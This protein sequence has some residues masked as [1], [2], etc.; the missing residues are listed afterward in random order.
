MAFENSVDKFLTKF[1]V[2]PPN[3]SL[4]PS[5]N[6]AVIFAAPS[7]VLPNSDISALVSPS[8]SS[9]ISKTGIPLSPS[10]CISSSPKPPDTVLA[11]KSVT[12]SNDPIW[13]LVT[14]AASVNVVSN[15]SVGSIPAAFNFMKVFVR[16]STPN[17]VLVANSL[18]NLNASA[19]CSVLPVTELKVVRKS[20]NSLV[21]ATMNDPTLTAPNAAK[22][23]AAP[24]NAVLNFRP[25]F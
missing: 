17:W 4:I 5:V 13:S 23:A 8:F 14:A 16:S 1:C 6:A 21:V 19:P 22:P 24:F 12:A 9:K 2:A 7:A 3:L 10:L 18:M 15:S 25:L 20:S 11:N